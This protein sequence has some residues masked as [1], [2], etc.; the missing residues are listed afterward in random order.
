MAT[1]KVDPDAAQD[2]KAVAMARMASDVAN[3][4]KV[5]SKAPKRGAKKG[6]GPML[7]SAGY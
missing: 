1:A 6:K 3:S 5:P 2:A 4:R 7:R